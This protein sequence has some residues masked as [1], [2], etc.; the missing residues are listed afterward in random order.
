MGAYTW[1]NEQEFK[2]ASKIRSD[3][4]INEALQEVRS[5]MP[6]WY[7]TERIWHKRKFSFWKG[8]Y[9]TAGINYTVYR[10][11]QPD[12]FEVRVQMSAV[13]KPTILNLLYGLYMGYNSAIKSK[14]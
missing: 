2:D 4:D 3:D 12:D 14:Q 13:N 11:T 1:L 10:R 6:E 7:V 5:L 9:N 8:F